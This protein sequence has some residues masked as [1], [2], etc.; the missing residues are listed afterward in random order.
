MFSLNYSFR[1]EGFVGICIYWEDR[2]YYIVNIY[3]SCMLVSKRRIWQELL[4][5]KRNVHAGEWCVRGDF[6]EVK[7]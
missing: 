6:N 5:F 7:N 1:G 3:S 4:T 2:H